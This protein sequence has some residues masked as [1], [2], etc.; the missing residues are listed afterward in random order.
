MKITTTVGQLKQAIKAALVAVNARTC[1]LHI[2]DGRLYVKASNHAGYCRV[3]LDVKTPKGT[4]AC[5]AIGTHTANV[6]FGTVASDMEVTITPLD[7]GIRL[8]YGGSNLKLNHSSG[9]LADEALFKMAESCEGRMPVTTCKGS[10]LISGFETTQHFAASSDVRQYLCGVFLEDH[11]GKLRMTATNGFML[12]SVDTDLR[13]ELNGFNAIIPNTAAQAIEVVF[14]ADEDIQLYQVGD[15]TSKKIVL[16]TDRLCWIN[17]LIAGE[18]PNY[19]PLLASEA[20]QRPAEIVVPR[21]E[22]VNAISR[23]LAVSSGPYVR[24]KFTGGVVTV[25]SPDEEQKE[26]LDVRAL[27]DEAFP[28]AKNPDWEA[29]FSGEL[30]SEIINQTPS[31]SILLRKSEDVNG[32]LYVRPMNENKVSIKWVAMLQAARV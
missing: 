26:Q 30:L 15:G 24:V 27:T 4:N 9:E 3:D 31:A 14:K 22:M 17:Y 21:K 10:D 16:K 20:T 19:R 29:G 6:I 5:A 13:C 7:A 8:R 32:K 23:V 18:Y 25:F 28:G 1:D 2:N 12:N 11:G